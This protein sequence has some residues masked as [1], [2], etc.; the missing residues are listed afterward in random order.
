MITFSENASEKIKDYIANAEDSP[1]GL[2]IRAMKVGNYTFRYAM[3]LVPEGEGQDGDTV[4]E[5]DGF[6]AYLDPQTSEWMNGA[7]IDFKTADGGEG[8]QINNPAAEPKWEDPVA[9]KVQAILDVRVIPMLAQHG[10]WIELIEVKDGIAYVQL[11]GG[12][13]GC[14]SA[15]ITLN[16]GIKTVIL[17]E[18]P[19]IKDIVDRT[20]HQA[21]CSP[22][23][24]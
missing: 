22:Y 14:A 23:K 11:G 7:S 9:Q 19:E 21:G 18:V 10:G 17:Q 24:P 3:Q 1:S 2:R 6:K 12:C 4:V 8:F 5:A 20:N 13:Q 15:G 16:E